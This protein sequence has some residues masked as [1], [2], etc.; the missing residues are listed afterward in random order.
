MAGTKIEFCKNT[1]PHVELIVLSA[2]FESVNRTVNALI[3]YRDAARNLIDA[4]DK[5]VALEEFKRQVTK[6]EEGE[7]K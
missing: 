3:A 2:E 6:I 4:T 7:G 5:D 1:L